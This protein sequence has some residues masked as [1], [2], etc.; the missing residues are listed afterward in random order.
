VRE[1]LLLDSVGTG[2]EAH[3]VAKAEVAAPEGCHVE[4]SRSYLK[5]GRLRVR[6]VDDSPDALD[7][8]AKTGHLTRAL[9]QVDI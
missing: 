2:I 3:L 6:I 9:G 5:E 8:E 1:A 7:R 4:T